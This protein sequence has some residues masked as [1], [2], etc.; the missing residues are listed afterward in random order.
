MLYHSAYLIYD[1]TH[2][3]GIGSLFWIVMGV[4]AIWRSVR[5]H[6]RRRRHMTRNRGRF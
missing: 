3:H 5:W 6:L 2:F 1:L 4:F